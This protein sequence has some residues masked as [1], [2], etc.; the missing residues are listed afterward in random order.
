MAGGRPT[1]MTDEVVQKLEEAFLMGCT[2]IEACFYANIAKQTL[3]T[4]QELNPEFKDRKEELKAN[5]IFL[6]RKSVITGVQ[7]DSDLALKFLERKCKDEFSLKSETKTEHSGSVALTN[8]LGELDGT[9]AG[10]PGTKE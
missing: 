7:N 1:S 8:L 3:Y 6:A 10:I 4:Y 5:P 2:D 9:T